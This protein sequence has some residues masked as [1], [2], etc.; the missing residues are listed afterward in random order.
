MNAMDRKD[1]VPTAQ[2]DLQETDMVA[3]AN[4]RLSAIDGNK[5]GSINH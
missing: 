1:R 3:I 4:P 5:Q 2:A